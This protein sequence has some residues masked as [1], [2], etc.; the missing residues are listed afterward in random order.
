MTDTFTYHHNASV[1]ATVKSLFITLDV[2]E[3]LQTD[4]ILD[5]DVMRADRIGRKIAR[6]EGKIEDAINS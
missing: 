5:G 1:N 6:I 2:L 4:A 3:D